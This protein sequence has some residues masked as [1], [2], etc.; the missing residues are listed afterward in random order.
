MYSYAPLYVAIKRHGQGLLM[1]VAMLVLC[2]FSAASPADTMTRKVLIDAKSGNGS[3]AGYD[4][5][6]DMETDSGSDVTA[7][8]KLPTIIRVTG[9]GLYDDKAKNSASK[10]LLAIR[11][12]RLDA[13]RNLAER[14]YGYSVTGTS[15]VKDFSLASDQF[16][17][18]VDSVVRGARV[19]SISDNPKTGI[20][21][22]VELEL[23]G[24]FQSCLNKLNNFKHRLD[25]LRPITTAGLEPPSS[26]EIERQ[27]REPRMRSIYHLN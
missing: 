27:R 16:A 17:T 25:C 19:V 10:R 7:V 24:G 20:E 5:P 2:L 11:A 22:V 12:S 4:D 15:S 13:Y 3:S 21:T 8:S 6:V 14:V 1:A 18:S 23:P 26:Q 9:Y